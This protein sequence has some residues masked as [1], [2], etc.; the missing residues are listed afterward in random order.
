MVYLGSGQLFMSSNIKA[1]GVAETEIITY[2]KNI[3][4]VTLV[5]QG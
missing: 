4:T 2:Y 5:K 3:I 1:V